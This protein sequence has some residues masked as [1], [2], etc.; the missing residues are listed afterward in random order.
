MVRYQ[1]AA[2]FWRVQLPVF[3]VSPQFKNPV[4]ARGIQTLL[5]ITSLPQ[6]I[7]VKMTTPTSRHAEVFVL[8][9]GHLGPGPAHHGHGAVHALQYGDE[10]LHLL[11]MFCSRQGNTLLSDG[12]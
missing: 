11:G 7:P 12:G 6:K 4:E 10:I 2:K 8:V 1:N 3:S 9:A 5:R